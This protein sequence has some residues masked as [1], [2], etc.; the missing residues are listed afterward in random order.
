MAKKTMSF[1]L[2]E[3]IIKII[4]D[5]KISQRLSSRSTALERLLL[6]KESSIDKE[7]IRSIVKEMISKDDIKVEK[8]DNIIVDEVEQKTLNVIGDAFD[9]MPD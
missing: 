9:S 2:E 4:D 8:E 7:T 3:D 1:S 5:Y 6:K